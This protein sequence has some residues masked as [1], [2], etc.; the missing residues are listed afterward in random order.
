MT[1]KDLVQAGYRYV[2]SLTHDEQEAESFVREAWARLF[3]SNKVH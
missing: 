1:D 3:R 2:L